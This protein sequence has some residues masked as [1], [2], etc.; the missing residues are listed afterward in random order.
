MGFTDIIQS[1]TSGDKDVQI[2]LDATG[3]KGQVF[4]QG[5]EV[6]HAA[7]GDTEGEAA[8]YEI[9]AWQ[10]ADFQII[11]CTAFPA[12]TIH[13]PAM[14]LLME[15]ARLTDELGDPGDDA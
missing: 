4:V 7:A 3:R 15:G 1:L 11:P 8:F 9:M 5:G 6:I 12:R 14:S 10:D 2:I 13:V